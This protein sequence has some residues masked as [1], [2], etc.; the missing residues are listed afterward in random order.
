MFN[1]VGFVEVGRERM[2]LEAVGAMGVGDLWK[3]ESVGSDD[4]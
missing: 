4:A 1:A 3:S 2:K